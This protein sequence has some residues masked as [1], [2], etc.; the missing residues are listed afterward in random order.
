MRCIQ[1]KIVF[2]KCLQ[3]RPPHNHPG[4]EDAEAMKY[5]YIPIPA[6]SKAPPMNMKAKKASG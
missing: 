3:L 5:K 1:P 4:G 6:I 2:M